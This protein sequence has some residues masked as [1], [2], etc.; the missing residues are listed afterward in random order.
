M[1][2]PA[3]HPGSQSGSIQEEMIMLKRLMPAS[4]L[5]GAFAVQA[6]TP[7]FDSQELANRWT[8]AYNEHNPAALAELYDENAVV[9]LHGSLTLKGRQAIHD[10]WV[11]DFRESNPITTLDVSHTI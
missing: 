5:L 1:N 8:T 3:H 4:L 7:G 2:L 9:M 10:Y 6:A 11:E